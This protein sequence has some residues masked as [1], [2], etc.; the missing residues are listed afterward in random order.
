LNELTE[1]FEK[2]G[3]TI[4]GVTDDPVSKLTSF[5]EDKGIKYVIAVGGGSG[6]TTAGIPHAW[7]VNGI[8]EIVWE[9]HPA[10]L[11]DDAIETQLKSVRLRPTFGLPKDLKKA[12]TSLNAGKYVDGI[13][14]LETYLKKPKSDEGEKA[15]KE[16]IEKVQTYGK[17]TLAQAD[18]Y[19][20]EGYYA[21]AMEAVAAL[22]KGF[23]GTEVGDEAKKKHDAWKKDD[24]V[25]TELEAGARVDKADGLTR[26]KKFKEAGAFL[27]RVLQVKKYEG[28]KARERAAAKLKSLGLAA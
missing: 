26:A 20:Q 15:A 22:E 3:L 18:G 4:I 19:A 12:E 21:E 24:K 14:A 17:E 9:G 7:L 8:G 6:Y 23:K 5:I 27:Q 28:T 16:A 2:R 25:K 13:K 1:K 11:K 10:E